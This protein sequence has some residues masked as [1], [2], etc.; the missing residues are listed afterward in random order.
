MK[1][2]AA[3]QKANEAVTKERQ[4]WHEKVRN[5]RFMKHIASLQ[6]LECG[7]MPWGLGWVQDLCE[8]VRGDMRRLE[9]NVY[10]FQLL[11]NQ[12]KDTVT[13]L[14]AKIL[15]L[16]TAVN[17]QAQQIAERYEELNKLLQDHVSKLQ[18][19]MVEQKT[20]FEAW[21]VELRGIG[22]KTI[23]SHKQ[24]EY[25][26][27][28]TL[29][30]LQN[31]QQHFDTGSFTSLLQGPDEGLKDGK[32]GTGLRNKLQT[33]MAAAARGE[34]T[35]KL[36]MEMLTDAIKESIEAHSSSA[37]TFLGEAIE[38]G[39]NADRL[40]AERDEVEMARDFQIA[41]QEAALEN[42]KIATVAK[43]EA[44]MSIN[45]GATAEQATAEAS[46]G[47]A[48]TISKLTK[49]LGTTITTLEAERQKAVAGGKEANIA[50]REAMLAADAKHKHQQME[51]EVELED[52][53]DEIN[54]N[55]E[56]LE[57]LKISVQK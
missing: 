31:A 28:N 45:G 5:D 1:K 2:E 44:E 8:H 41:R 36:V 34:D 25:N 9:S 47:E 23:T 37:A 17:S 53:T 40:A 6:D 29:T 12:R 57:S 39:I 56:H 3:L 30:V 21:E 32:Y 24:L 7:P 50:Q 54:K 16:E 49:L 14:I 35:H 38:A 10:H 43:E 19:K 15:Q 18:G 27:Q 22:A 13:L 33:L 48:E 11:V 4:T 46:N 51:V 42:M 20:N 26:L 52:L 55:K